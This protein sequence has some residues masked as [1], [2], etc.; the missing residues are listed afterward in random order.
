M[1]TLAPASATAG[2]STHAPVRRMGP[3]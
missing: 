1:G 2:L 3:L